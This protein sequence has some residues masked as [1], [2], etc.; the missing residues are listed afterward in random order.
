MLKG[1]NSAAQDLFESVSE[2]GTCWRFVSL[3]CDRWAITRDGEQVA[4]GTGDRASVASGVGKFQ[5]LRRATER[6]PSAARA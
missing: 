3:P 2:D 6:Q 4:S 1:S 5:S